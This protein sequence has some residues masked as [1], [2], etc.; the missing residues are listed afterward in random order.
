MRAD[1]NAAY[2]SDDLDVDNLAEGFSDESREVFAARIAVT[3]ALGIAPGEVVAD[4]GAG[5]G[6]YLHAFSGAVGPEGRVFAVDISPLLVD[7]LGRFAAQEGL[8]NVEARLGGAADTGLA[9]AS[10]DL[11]FTSNVYHHFER[12]GAMNAH[13]FDIVAPGGRLA[14]LDFRKG[15]DAPDWIERHVRADMAGVIG[16]VT[17]AG[18]IFTG[19]VPVSGLEDNY[20]LVFTRP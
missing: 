20:L 7:Y 9:P 17:S 11:A 19:E 14:I 5:T 18:F 13:L 3:E 12:P 2:L 16:E 10:L 1:I 15:P 8:A 4:I 6:I